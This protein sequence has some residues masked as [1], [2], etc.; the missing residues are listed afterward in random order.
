MNKEALVDFVKAAR[1]DASKKQSLAKELCR[2]I[3]NSKE[4]KRVDFLPEGEDDENYNLPCTNIA[5]S[6]VSDDV[7]SADVRSIWLDDVDDIHV[8]VGYYYH[9]GEIEELYIENDA[10]F[11]WLEM[12][13]WLA[14]YQI[15]PYTKL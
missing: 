11:D 12:L 2:D 3:L 6:C 5:N 8:K 9:D 14:V 13:E 10:E 7:V 15:V 4:N 1:E